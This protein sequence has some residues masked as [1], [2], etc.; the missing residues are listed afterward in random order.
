MEEKYLA[1]S[2]TPPPFSRLFSLIKQYHSC[3]SWQPSV[4]PFLLYRAVPDRLISLSYLSTLHLDPY[5][6]PLLTSHFKFTVHTYA[7][8]FYNNSL[9]RTRLPRPPLNNLLNCTVRYRAA[10]FL[11]SVSLLSVWEQQYLA[12]CTVSCRVIPLSCLS[13]L[14]GGEAIPGSLYCTMPRHL[15]G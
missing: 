15:S 4:Q 10:S 5:A 11:Y 9:L 6:P 3:F 12:P 14:C 1:P 13:S 7:S 2:S 8:F